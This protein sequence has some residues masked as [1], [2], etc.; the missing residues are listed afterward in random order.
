[1]KIIHT[2]RFAFN[3]VVKPVKNPILTV[4]CIESTGIYE[5]SV[6]AADLFWDVYKEYQTWLH[7]HGLD[8]NDPPMDCYIPDELI[9]F[10]MKNSQCNKTSLEIGGSK[11][12]SAI[13]LARIDNPTK[14]D[15]G[16]AERQ[17]TTSKT[18]ADYSLTFC[19]HRHVCYGAS[20][21]EEISFEPGLRAS[22]VC[23]I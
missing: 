12:E 20:G 22:T 16:V 18:N 8:K 11:T 13:D 5:I 6:D 19:R 4:E 3:K 2:V 1:M 17:P 9:N 23:G 21:Q 7:D 15:D 10:F 14:V